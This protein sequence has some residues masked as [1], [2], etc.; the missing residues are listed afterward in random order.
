MNKKKFAQKIAEWYQENKRQLPWRETADPYRI[1]LS[2]IILQQT[3]VAQGLPYYLRFIKRFPDVATLARSREQDILRLWQGLGYYTRARNL[4]RCAKAIVSQN[5]GKFPDNFI[6]LQ[7]LPGIGVY[8]AAAIASLAFHEAVAVVDGNVYRVLA[9]IFG[10]DQDIASAEGRDYFFSK[11]QSLVP[12]GFPGIF[13]QAMMEFGAIHCLPKNPKCADCIFKRHCVAFARD[14]QD[15][16]PVKTKKLK[17]RRRYFYYFV[18]EQN[19]KWGMQKRE[20]KDIWHGLY[21]FYL[22]ETPR[23]R[24]PERLVKENEV[25]KSLKGE[26]QFDK[27]STLFKHNLSHQKLLARFIPVTIRSTEL[28]KASFKFEKLR[29]YSARE[30]NKLPKPALVTRYLKESLF[31]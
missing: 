17:V 19:K 23:P 9:R 22:V 7:K 1:W 4:H 31:L 25:L 27:V 30:I 15:R 29:F 20:G 10:E 8:T 13:N 12:A 2:E 26:I 5:Q 28:K 18:M 24:K 11:A 16:L 21:D 14:W 6:D 3:R